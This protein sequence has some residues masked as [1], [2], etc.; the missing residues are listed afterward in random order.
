MK[1]AVTGGS[2]FLGRMTAEKLLAR[3]AADDVVV[4][5]R[6][7]EA[8]DEAL[9]ARGVEVRQADYMDR[10]ALRAA[11]EGID[12]AMITTVTF[13]TTGLRVEQHRNA[14]ES[15]RDAGVRR[16]VLP[17]M[18]NVDA[19]H[20]TGAYA[21]EYPASERVLQESGVEWTVLQNGPYAE[22]IVPRAALA[23]ATGELTSNAG[24]GRMAPVTHADCAEV[25]AAALIDEGHAGRTYVITGPE[26]FTHAQL[27]ELFSEISGRPV[28]LVELSDEDHPPRLIQ[29]GIP[30]PFPLLMTR[31]LK[32]IRL[33]YF[34][35]CTTAVPDLVGHPAQALRTVL[36][37]AG[38]VILRPGR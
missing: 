38:D 35:D 15:A 14:I 24:D 34:D 19:Q 25:A 7:P 13:E 17:S 3:V 29:D 26:L 20:P 30:A 31:H 23:A 9:V 5:T 6:R 10:P 28:R 18:P 27:A 37:A 16:V 2:G 8:V 32:A 12:R 21:L 4:I 11:F 33:G 1:Y 22:N 36:E